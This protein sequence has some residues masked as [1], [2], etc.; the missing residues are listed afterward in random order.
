MSD[1][2]GYSHGCCRGVQSPR[3]DTLELEPGEFVYR[4]EGR[5]DTKCIVQLTFVT[6]KRM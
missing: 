3:P 5:S 2:T 6:N 4:I 1:N